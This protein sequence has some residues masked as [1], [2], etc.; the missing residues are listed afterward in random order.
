MEILFMVFMVFVSVMCLFSALVVLR[1]IVKE[2]AESKRQAKAQTVQVVEKCVE[3]PCVLPEP[4][5]PVVEEV[6]EE[7]ALEEVAVTSVEEK[8]GNISFSANNKQTL[9][10]K[11]ASLS[12]KDKSRYNE[13][14]EYAKKVEGNR[15]FKND[16]YEEYKVGKNRL[17]RMLIKRGVIICEFILQNSDF[18]NYVNENKISVK[19]SATSLKILDSA[20][21]AVA[22]NSIDIAV[23]AINEEKEYKKQ[24]AREKRRAKNQNKA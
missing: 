6:K 16:R 15:C 11:Y 22:K 8:E 14:V 23:N 19:Q 12:Q 21:V 20:S 7:T 5:K 10:E 9:D 4:T 2:I 13:I 24:L 1:D 3:T 18:K 17:V